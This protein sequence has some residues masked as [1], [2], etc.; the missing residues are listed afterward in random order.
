MVGLRASGLLS[1]G[2]VGDWI[3]R[4][5]LGWCL[6]WLPLRLLGVWLTVILAD[7]TVGGYGVCYSLLCN[8]LIVI[9]D[10]GLVIRVWVSWLLV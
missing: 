6:Y 9:L 2:I 10:C 3:W 5:L 7:G 8:D 4:A 1:F